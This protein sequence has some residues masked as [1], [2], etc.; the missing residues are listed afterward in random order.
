M[1]QQIILLLLI[2]TISTIDSNSSSIEFD[3]KQPF[4]E[5]NHEFTFSNTADVPKFFM[6]EIDTDT[7][8]HYEYQCQ[9][10]EKITDVV[11]G[12]PIFII[13]AQAG[14]CLINIFS[15]SWVFEVKGTIE[16]HPLEKEIPIK[17][18]EIRKV[19]KNYMVGFDE[20]FPSLV[21]SI[22]NL[23]EDII[24]NFSYGKSS[25]IIDGKRISLN[26]PFR[27]CVENDCKDDIKSYEFIKEKDYK[28][29]IKV[30]EIAV[31]SKRKYYMNC[32]AFSAGNNIAVNSLIYLM[33]LLLL[34][35]LFN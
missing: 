8:L 15:T 10:S 20:K 26:N 23:E 6:V 22:S 24:I 12:K 1:Y 33:L 28:V 27:I 11:T 35:E 7:I 19:R 18:D 13:K 9:G 17:L 30:Q 4:D 25:V 5:N 16:I 3:V 2:S 14:E 34:Y 31:G 32:F 29:E 21:Y